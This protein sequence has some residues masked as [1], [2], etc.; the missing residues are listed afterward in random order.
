MQKRVRTLCRVEVHI[1]S[2][3]GNKENGQKAIIE[4][5]VNKPVKRR[6]H[7]KSN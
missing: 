1:K 2:K 3:K 5:T 4:Q 6:K 7:K